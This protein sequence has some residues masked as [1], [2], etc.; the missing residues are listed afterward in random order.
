VPLRPNPP[1]GTAVA[2]VLALIA[3]VGDYRRRHCHWFSR[4]GLLVSGPGCWR[5]MN[6]SA[7]E[8]VIED[9]RTT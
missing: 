4:S 9:R 5:T 6:Q 8:D 2:C 3:D 7:N 1:E